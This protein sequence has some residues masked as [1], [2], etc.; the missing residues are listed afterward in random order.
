MVL[1]HVGEVHIP[2]EMI[3]KSTGLTAEEINGLSGLNKRVGR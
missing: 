3:I 1:G 2:E